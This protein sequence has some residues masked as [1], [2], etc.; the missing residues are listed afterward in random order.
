MKNLVQ[1]KA[2]A[3]VPAKA[4]RPKAG[5]SGAARGNPRTLPPRLKTLAGD[6]LKAFKS[7]WIGTLLI[8][9]AT[10]V[11]F[12]PLI[13][14]VGTYSE[15]GDAMFN[16][17]TLSRDQHCILR[18][19]CPQYSNANIYFPHKD[20]MLYSE[21]QLSAGLLTMPLYWINQNPI[22][23][24]NVFTILS[25]FLGGWFMYLL[26]KY[27]S[28]G[29]EL[30]SV[31]AGLIFEFAPFKMAAISHLQNLSIFYLPLAALLIF[32]YVERPK[33]RYLGFL[34]IALALQFYASWYQMVFVLIT[35]GVLL[36][37]MLVFRIVRWRLVAALGLVTLLAMIS[38]LPLAKAYVK[39]S[40]DNQA[41]FDIRQQITYS[42]SLADYIK[43]NAGTLLGKEYYK[44]RPHAQVN[45][46]N[47][48]SYSYH[49]LVLY[50]VAICLTTIAFRRRKDGREGRRKYRLIL[51]FVAMG[52]VGFIISLGPVLKLKG[53]YSYADLSN[54]FNLVIPLP[55]I[56][57]DKFLP[58]LSFIRAIGRASVI[59]L[60]ALCCMLALFPLY[61]KKEK[62]YQK[63]GRLIAFVV[64]ALVLIEILP[65]HLAPMTKSAYSYDYTI[66]KVYVFI[67]SHQEINDIIVLSADKDYP[68]ATIPVAR[69]EQVLW[70]GYDNR[71]VF[72]G[73]SGYTPPEY[74]GQY[75]DFVDFHQDDVAKMKALHLRYVLVDKLLSSSNPQLVKNVSAALPHK[76][77]EDGRYALFKID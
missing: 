77:Y 6:Y 64:S 44:L 26:A 65:V 22:F 18:Q 58:Q 3:K 14:H 75:A 23:S 52:I 27:L 37:G 1:S 68:G 36:G 5:V 69:A 46:F 67:K 39:F 60:F 53:S 41:T 4:S 63:H 76:V 32:K 10:L 31:L 34:F 11:F 38:T 54:G 8:L 71:N 62:F 28:R 42:S 15:G 21:T 66:P 49:G 51:T 12:W 7:H 13:M 2:A 55:Y 56:F 48:D 29:N 72:N 40:K 45:S 61:A 50:A 25:F 73:Y 9:A 74:F 47:P 57:V 59:L 16:A 33:R 35:L 20:T 17:W 70:A 24:Y 30:Y 19:D 43:P